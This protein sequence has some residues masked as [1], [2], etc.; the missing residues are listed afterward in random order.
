M[1]FDRLDESYAMVK[2]NLH[3]DNVILIGLPR[4]SSKPELC[5]FQ[6]S[7]YAP[8]FLD[9]ACVSRNISQNQN[10]IEAMRNTC[11]HSCL[12]PNENGIRWTIYL[13]MAQDNG[14][15]LSPAFLHLQ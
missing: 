14:F 8:L 2:S 10:C 7:T 1:D 13:D 5:Q 4:L 6:L 3:F 12:V 11:S 15:T 9:K